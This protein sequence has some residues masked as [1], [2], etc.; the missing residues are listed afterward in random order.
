[1]FEEVS[2]ELSAPGPMFVLGNINREIILAEY[3]P[4]D[5]FRKKRS[6]RKKRFASPKSIKISDSNTNVSSDSEP[7]LPDIFLDVTCHDELLIIHVLSKN[8][9]MKFQRRQ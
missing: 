5:F 3:T 7:P 4:C 1:M 9:L 2:S 8:P 6:F